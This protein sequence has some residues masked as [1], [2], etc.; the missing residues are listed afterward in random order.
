LRIVPVPCDVAILALTGESRFT[1]RV[2]SASSIVSP[3]T[4]TV[5]VTLVAPTGIESCWGVA[6]AV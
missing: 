5:N 6:V 1:R 4:G 3:L 2:S